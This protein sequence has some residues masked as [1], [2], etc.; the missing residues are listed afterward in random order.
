MRILT[1]TSLYP[2]EIQTRN[3]IFVEQRIRQL[4]HYDDIS[5]K[6]VAPVPWFPFKGKIFGE[7]SNYAKIPKKEYR[8]GIE[9][10]HPKFPAIPKIGMVLS[11]FLLASF[12]WPTFNRIQKAGFDFDLIDAHYFYPDG[13]A[14]SILG[15]WY[16]KP[17]IITARGTDVNIIPKFRIPRKLI[18]LAAKK[19]KKII[20]V[21]TALK[22]KLIEIGVDRDKIKVLRNGVDLKLF[23][24]VDKEIAR[25]Q[26]GISYDY[27]LAVG[28]LVEEKGHDLIISALPELKNTKLIIIGNGKLKEKLINF[29]KKHN[30]IERVLFINNVTQEELKYY[31]SA[32]KLL[33]LTSTREGMPNVLLESIACGTP[34]IATN[35]GGV[36]EIIRSSEAGIIINERT[37]KELVKAINAIMNNYPSR[38]ETRKYAESFG[39]ENIIKEQICV[40]RNSCFS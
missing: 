14:A 21:T 7:Y 26:I 31:Y 39:W 16:R 20:T 27:I 15:H 1:F 32:A 34:V 4:Q 28:N 10:Y 12:M 24:M 36:P 35:V 19:S 33:I 40:M 3:G 13:V 25:K 30:V 22:Y 8:N 6:V 5:I 23:N 38:N 11:P 37:T 18:L 2:N 29:A 9:I 17:V